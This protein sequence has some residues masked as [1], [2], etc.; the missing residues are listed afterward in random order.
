MYRA[1]G[2]EV[3]DQGYRSEHWLVSRLLIGTLRPDC[4]DPQALERTDRRYLWLRKRLAARADIWRIFPEGWHLQQQL[5]LT[6]CAITK[7]QL[8]DILQ[9][10][11][12]WDCTCGGLIVVVLGHRV[13]LLVL[14]L[15]WA[16]APFQGPVVNTSA[17]VGGNCG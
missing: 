9:A 6:F 17:V 11:V 7:S 10:K 12:G 8:A 13:T 14:A 15:W 16:I 5:C 4:Y 1:L 2:V 3:I